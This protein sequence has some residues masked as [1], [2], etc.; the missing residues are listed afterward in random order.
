MFFNFLSRARPDWAYGYLVWTVQYQTSKLSGPEIFIFQDHRKVW[1]SGGASIIWWAYS[2][3]ISQAC[4]LCQ[5]SWWLF[6]NYMDKMRGRGSKMSVFVHAHGMK[7][8]HAGC[9]GSK[10]WQKK[11]P[12]SCWMPLSCAKNGLAFLDPRVSLAMQGCSEIKLILKIM[13]LNPYLYVTQY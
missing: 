8:V 9:G 13:F 3:K 7:I 4:K 12:R 1:K 2:A 10:K 11:G 6:K 5:F